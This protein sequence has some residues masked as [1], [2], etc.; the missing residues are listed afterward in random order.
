MKYKPNPVTSIIYFEFFN[1]AKNLQKLEKQPSNIMWSLS[2]SSYYTYKVLSNKYRYSNDYTVQMSGR[3]TV[4][5]IF[6]Q[7]SI[8]AQYFPNDSWT[9]PA[10]FTET[11]PIINYNWLL[12]GPT[13]SMIDYFSAIYTLTVTG[14]YSI[15]LFIDSSEHGQL[16]IL[17]LFWWSSN[18]LHWWSSQGNFRFFVF[19]HFI[20][21]REG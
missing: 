14:K 13:A 5:V 15:K 10:T 12:G 7:S 19:L 4:L 11:V 8:S 9:P 16:C 2:L 18:T 21:L 3:I 1:W 20:L 17:Y 6:F